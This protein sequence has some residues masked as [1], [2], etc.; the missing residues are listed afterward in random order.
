MSGRRRRS[1]GWPVAARRRRRLQEPAEEAETPGVVHDGEGDGGEEKGGAAIAQRAVERRADQRQEISE[2]GEEE[3]GRERGEGKAC[4]IADHEGY[5]GELTGAR[6]DPV[7]Q[8]GLRTAAPIAEILARK[9][10]GGRAR[11]IV[12]REVGIE[13]DLAARFDEA[14]RQLAVL[15][16]G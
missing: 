4:G 9:R 15:V 13:P 1:Q 10:G 16:V 5:G 6:H 8:N 2:D 7:L 14:Q 12:D 3:P 11:I